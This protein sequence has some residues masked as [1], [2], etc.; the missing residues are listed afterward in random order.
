M[1]SHAATAEPI[2]PPP[3]LWRTV[4]DAVRGVEFDYTAINL[5]RSILLLA[6]PM[7]LE[8]AMESVFAVVDVF[9][10]SRLGADAVATV[11]IT[12]SLITLVFAVALGLSMATTAMVAR[13][14]GEGDREAACV[15]A[16]QAIWIGV[17]FSLLIGVTGFALAPDMLRWMGA[18]AGLLETGSGYARVLLGG[19]GTVLMLFLINAIFRGAGNAAI[20]MRVLWIA[21]GINLVLDPCLIFGLGPFPEMGVT[22]AAVATTIGRGVG[23]AVQLWALFYGRGRIALARRHLAPHLDIVGR[24]LRVASGGT[25]QH[26]VATASWVAMVRIIAIFG[27]PALAGYTIAIRVIVFAI[28]PSWGLSNAAATLVGQNLG[29]GKPERAEKSVWLSGLYNMLFLGL[30]S[31]VFIFAPGQVVGLFTSDAEVLRVGA[32]C[33]RIIAYGY[34]AYAYGMVMVQAF[35]GAGD[36]LT[37][38]IINLGCYWLFQIPLGYALAVHWQFADNGVPWAILAA[39]TV[40]TGIAI[41]LFRRGKWKL[42]AI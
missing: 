5:N 19:C 9:F 1:Q 22:G 25:M 6:I 40:M 28:L 7:V 29:A 34:V 14:I 35:N 21:N 26:L 27:S 41:L 24:L 3:S 12:E 32:S 31:L 42:Q 23:V 20:A 39:E 16:M 11:G 33:L 4:R 18:E 2:P 10:V 36:T 17:F 38:T 15:A 8:M 37:P 30:L 13:R